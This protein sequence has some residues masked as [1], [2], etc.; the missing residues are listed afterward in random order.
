MFWWRHPQDV[1]CLHLRKT[2][3][4][5]LRDFLIKENILPCSYIFKRRLQ[6]IFKTSCKNVSKT[7]IQDVFKTFLTH[8]QDVLQRRSREV[9]K[10]YHQVMTVLHGTICI[11]QLYDSYSVL[12]SKELLHSTIRM[13]RFNYSNILS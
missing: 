8:G 12:K 3:S 2:S 4:R 5:L 11:I 1:F 9:F 10:I 13:I 6:D 7:S